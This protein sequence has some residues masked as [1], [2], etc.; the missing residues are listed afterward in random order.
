MT[1]MAVGGGRRGRSAPNS[2][3]GERKRPPSSPDFNLPSGG[4]EAGSRRVAPSIFNVVE[5]PVKQFVGFPRWTTRWEF[6]RNGS[7]PRQHR[8]SNGTGGG[9]CGASGPIEIVWSDVSREK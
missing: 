2:E 3:G 8:E 4:S 9:C 1:K 5:Q 7:F 6:L